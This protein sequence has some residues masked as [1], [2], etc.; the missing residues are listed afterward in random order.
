MGYLRVY[1]GEKLTGQFELQEDMLTIGRTSDNKLVL[2]DPGVS[3]LHATIV[4]ED[5]HYHII[6]HQS[7][8]GVFLNKKRIKRERLKYHDD[9]QIHN[10]VIK[11]MAVP[12]LGASMGGH[13]DSESVTTDDKTMFVSLSNEKQLDK[14]RQKTRLAYLESKDKNG[15]DTKHVIKSTT[16]IIGK[17]AGADVRISGWF[18][19]AIAAR[20]ERQGSN[21]QL[22]P[23]TRG[24]VI[25]NGRPV[26]KPVLIKDGFG[27][28][29][30][31]QEFKFFHRLTKS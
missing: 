19:P 23:M 30:R 1:N 6:D 2:S 29:V 3:R 26:T 18:A 31:G 12:R 28:I 4:F 17:S 25:F 14:L 9:I 21:F 11:F 22:I 16:V 7:R 10:F 20:I 8:N 24:K 15:N 5:G 27:F 13:D